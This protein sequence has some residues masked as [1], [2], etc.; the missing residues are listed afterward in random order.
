[1]ILLYSFLLRYRPVTCRFNPRHN[2]AAR[3][4]PRKPQKGQNMAQ[5]PV[6]RKAKTNAKSPKASNAAT[7]KARAAQAAPLNDDDAA[8]SAA[9]FEAAEAA[10]AEKEAA[11]AAKSSALLDLKG[12]IAD[13][14]H[15]LKEGDKRS[16]EQARLD[17]VEI[18]RALNDGRALFTKQG[19]K[20]NQTDEKGFGKWLV[21]QGFNL[22][23]QRPTRAGAAW[24]ANV[25]DFK[26]GLYALFPTESVDGEPLRR[27][28]RTLQAWVREQVYAAFQDAWE[29]D[30]DNIEIAADVD[31]NK[32]QKS[33]AAKSTMPNVYSALSEQAADAERSVEMADAKLKEAKTAAARTQAADGYMRACDHRD[34]LAT[35]K[36]IM[37]QHNE[38]EMLSF[39]IGWRPKVE[40]VSFKD[41]DVAAAADRLFSLLKQ[42]PQAGE[43]Y[44]ALGDL[45]DKALAKVA[46]DEGEV[47]DDDTEGDVGAVAAPINDPEG[48]DDFEVSDEEEEFE[49]EDDEFEDD[50]FEDDDEG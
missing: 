18:G 24:L 41:S 50:E 42:H 9:A 43:V 2:D 3:H 20:G 31:G 12:R 37:D 1:M 22:L 19:E 47:S 38:S 45:I 21:E 23:G 32:E 44:D 25:Y 16:A 13:T 11:E 8:A 4:G 36:A 30:G 40:P 5:T 15:S 35:R 17:W 26:P 39:F 48:D 49:I 46:E 27:S 34:R 6:A 29:I 7:T 14:L 33:L 10:K 28:P